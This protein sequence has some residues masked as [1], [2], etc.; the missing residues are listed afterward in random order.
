MK[1]QNTIKDEIRELVSLAGFEEANGLTVAQVSHFLCVSVARLH[2]MRLAGKG[3]KY[4]RE[5][6]RLLYSPLSVM[7]FRAK[8]SINQKKYKRI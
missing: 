8:N 5:D 7:A 2:Q 6:G 3:P 1:K 4:H